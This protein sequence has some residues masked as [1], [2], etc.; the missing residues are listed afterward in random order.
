MK[1]AI[2]NIVD[3]S[4]KSRYQL[5]REIDVTSV[6]LNSWYHGQVP[7]LAL[8]R[9]LKGISQTDQELIENINEILEYYKK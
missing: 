1:N 3:S 2:Q 5:C 6:T 9:F 4:G 7:K 8:I